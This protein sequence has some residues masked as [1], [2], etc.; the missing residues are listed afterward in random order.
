ME[1]KIQLLI[2]KNVVKLSAITLGL[3]L[4]FLSP[5]FIT[6][7]GQEESSRIEFDS[8]FYKINQKA[9]LTVYD[10]SANLSDESM[11]I[12]Y[13]NITSKSNLV[14]TLVIL[15]ETS[16]NS[17][18][19]KNSNL[20]FTTKDHFFKINGMIKMS[21]ND[22]S[23][24]DNQNQDT[25][26]VKVFSSSDEEGITFSIKETSATS[27]KFIENFTLHYK[28]SKFNQVQVREWDILSI[29]YDN[30]LEKGIVVP[31]S[32]KSGTAIKV[33]EEGDT[34]EAS[35][36][37]LKSSTI[38]EKFDE[39]NDDEAIAG[40]GTGGLTIS[41]IFLQVITSLSSDSDK[42]ETDENQTI[43]IPDWIKDVAEFW[44]G[45][46]IEDAE[47]IQAIQYL[48]DN[49]IITV[50]QAQPGVAGAGQ[51]VP[52]WVKNNACWWSQG[53]ISDAEFTNA[54]QYLVKEGIIVIN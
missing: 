7:F 8:E 4:V 5:V 6:S 35:Y 9:K 51:Q 36:L 30:V 11:E 52:Q 50:P 3:V 2:F 34:I 1:M 32:T 26:E 54:I 33:S 22:P 48:L 13:A 47:F 27:G 16:P 20:L 29:K 44:C 46:Q 31:Q 28:P 39:K 37:G 38:I 14:E 42:N 17:G 23:K 43:I 15:T 18:V 21:I 25:V 24:S 53:Q 41:I 10:S 12:I 45:D 19:F 40:G 49:Q